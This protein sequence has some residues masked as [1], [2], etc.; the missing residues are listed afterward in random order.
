MS[1]RNELPKKQ[2][3]YQRGDV[4]V[5][6][7]DIDC[8]IILLTML[9]RYCENDLSMDFNSQAERRRLG[10]ELGINLDVDRI[11][12]DDM[13]RFAD[14]LRAQYPTSDHYVT[15][16]DFYEQLERMQSCH[17][18]NDKAGVRHAKMVSRKILETGGLSLTDRTC[19]HV[20]VFIPSEPDKLSATV[21]NGPSAHYMEVEVDY[22]QKKVTT[23][24]SLERYAHY[25]TV[26]NLVMHGLVRTLY[27]TPEKAPTWQAAEEWVPDYLFGLE[28][29]HDDMLD[30]EKDHDP[31]K[32]TG[33]HTRTRTHAHTHTHHT[34]HTQ[35]H[36]HTNTHTQTHQPTRRTKGPP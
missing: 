1:L 24:C 25:Q 28:Q 18:H 27:D 7:N 26:V 6:E 33:T 3:V 15:P 23:K 30:G 16:A 14:I 2:A 32:P 11:S 31:E 34:P 19:V 20:R 10:T 29:G 22:G 35:T 5:Q 36:K 21:R 4:P 13:D 12:M 8:G 17:Q 9:R